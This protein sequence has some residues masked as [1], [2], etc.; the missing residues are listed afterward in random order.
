MKFPLL[1][2][3]AA[4]GSASLLPAQEA[5]WRSALYPADWQPGFRDASGRF[6]HDFS[7]AG[8][9]RGEK[10][11]PHVEG[12][13]IDVTKPPY[14][15]DPTGGKDSTSDIQ[16]ALDAAAVKAV[17]GWSFMPAVRNGQAIASIVQVPVNFRLSD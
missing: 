5:A 12:P 15:A 7:Y 9:H 3:L 14:Q 6:L 11:V 13:V 16:A 17:R 10:P 8:Y 2:V 1:C 4:I